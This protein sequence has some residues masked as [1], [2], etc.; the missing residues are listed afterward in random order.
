[1]AYNTGAGNSVEWREAGRSYA[2]MGD[3]S[4]P[5]LLA[6]ANDLQTI[7]RGRWLRS[8]GGR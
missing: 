3:L 5:E 7:D 6:L 8:L 4:L 1:M 2:I